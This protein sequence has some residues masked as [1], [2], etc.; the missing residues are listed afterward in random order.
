M[1]SRSFLTAVALALAGSLHAADPALTI[2][3]QNFAV[4]RETVSLN[5]KAGVNDVR[6]AGVTAQ[7]EPDSVIL[8]DPAGKAPLQILEQNYRN[9]PV[10]QELLLSLFE[11]QEIEFIAR[12]PQ[13]ADRVVTGKI[14]RSGY[15]PGGSSVQPIIEVQGKLQF[16]LPGEPRFPALGDDTVLQPTLTWKL[17]AGAPAKLD[18]ELAF[19]TGG[20][21]WLAS[22]NL[23][24]PETA[25]TID[26]VGWITM[27][28][29]SGAT[30]PEAKIKL[31]AG[32]VNKIAPPA[33]PEGYTFSGAIGG[34][35]DESKA[36]VT[37]KAFDEF[38]LYTLAN[39]TTLRD[40]ETKQVEFVRATGVQATRLY[41]YDPIMAEGDWHLGQSVGEDADYGT[42]SSKK[43]AVYREFKNSEANH[44]G[45]AL[46]KGRVRFYAQDDAQPGEKG[47]SL[48]FI[49]E[50]EIDHTPKDELIRMKTGD[51]FDLVGERKRTDFKVNQDAHWATETFEIKVRNRKKTP[52]EIRVVEHLYRWT[53]WT[54]KEKSQ[55]F[56]KTDAQTVEF[57]VPVKPSEEKIVTYKVRYTW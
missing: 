7:V 3:N 56:T 48:E 17:N 2:Y 57:L 20:L 29:E 55:D 33:P 41:I 46:P 5:L 12:E 8:R 4:V 24:A 21:T 14:I 44:L 15:V 32:D 18:A 22:Y 42:T 6:F 26:L 49:G 43:V 40:K 53:N 23:V 37:E 13:K 16:S 1:K 19:I 38:H 25:D 11:G 39:P 50:N 36:V 47:G 34:M 30:F 28:N 31:M 9:D 35:K 10:S 45:I 54:I 52:V 27:K 51:S